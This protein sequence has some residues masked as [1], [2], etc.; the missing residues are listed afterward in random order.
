MK[1][2][3]TVALVL[4]ALTAPAFADDGEAPVTHTDQLIVVTPN[5]PIVINNGGAPGAAPA[6]APVAAPVATNGAPQNEDWN[7]VSHINGSLVKVGEKSDYLLRYRKTNISTNPIGWMFGFYGVS[8]SHALSNNIAVRGDANII[9]FENSE[10]YEV[11]ASLPIYFR[12]VYSGPFIEPGL[13]MR[14]SKSKDYYCDASYGSCGSSSETF[15]G[16]EMLFGWSWIFDS[17]LNVAFAVGAARNLSPQMDEYGYSD[18]SV[19][20]A[21]YFRIGYAF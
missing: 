18:D 9:S 11:G 21:G 15:T 12:R 10:G 20:P 8:V 1:T 17:G 19:Q 6:A 4:A 7:N 13:I 16:P 3:R 5:P 14:G 2:V